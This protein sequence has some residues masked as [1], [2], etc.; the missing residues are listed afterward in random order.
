MN[1][2]ELSAL[3]AEILAGMGE[4]APQVKAGPYYPANSGPQQRSEGGSA[5]DVSAIDL[6]KLYLT[7]NPKN[8]AEYLKLKGRTPARLGMGKALGILVGLRPRTEGSPI[9]GGNRCSRS[10]EC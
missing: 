9:V 2:E 1:K 3:V 5:E 8:K 10:R 4:E 7:E 6:R